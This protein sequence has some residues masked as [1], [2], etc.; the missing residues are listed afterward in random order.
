[1]LTLLTLL[2][3]QCLPCRLSVSDQNK[4]HLMEIPSAI[5]TL[6]AGIGINKTGGETKTDPASSKLR[7]SCCS[8]L[9]QLAAS[10]LTRS[11]IEGHG[12]LDDLGQVIAL[13][14]VG[15]QTK[16]DAYAVV[17]AV[18]QGTE[19]RHVHDAVDTEGSKHIMLSCE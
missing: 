17:F 4:N 15:M 10:E 9:A 14:G 18:Q 19:E 2:T 1:M 13:P 3:L 8:A 12:I 11:L 16:N 5:D 6:Q 7:A